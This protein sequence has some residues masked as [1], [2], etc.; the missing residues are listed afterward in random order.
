MKC[1][2]ISGKNGV[3]KVALVDD[4]DYERVKRKKWWMLKGG[5]A[6]SK[7]DGGRKA[8]TVLLH[9]FILSYS[10]GDDVDHINRNKLDNRKENLRICTRSQNIAN[11]PAHRDSLS[12]Y[13]GVHFVHDRKKKWAVYITKDKKLHVV[14]H[15]G[16]AQQA[17]I[18]YNKEAKKLFGEFAYQ[19]Q[20]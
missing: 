19:N 13:R 14:G 18:V 20:V 4:E 16:T 11:A 5:Y 3:G 9:R 15:Y 1:L 6:F 10:G 17:A 7:A 8:P 2:E 12:G